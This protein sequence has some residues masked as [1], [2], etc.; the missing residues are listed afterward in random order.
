M[1]FTPS[2][3]VGKGGKVYLCWG[4]SSAMKRGN[5]EHCQPIV[6]DEQSRWC[7]GADA[8]EKVGIR[9]RRKPVGVTSRSC[10]LPPSSGSCTALSQLC[11]TILFAEVDR[12]TFQSTALSTAM[13][14]A[15]PLQPSTYLLRAKCLTCGV[16]DLLH[17]NCLTCSSSDPSSTYTLF[18]VFP[19]QSI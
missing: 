12:R 18:S 14:I 4:V 7:G 17:E 15:A 5:E 19:Q 13:S 11:L 2:G 3:R 6:I 16:V 10:L 9:V 1:I 8:A